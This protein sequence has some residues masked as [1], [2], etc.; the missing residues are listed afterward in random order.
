MEGDD[1]ALAR[2]DYPEFPNVSDAR[3][4]RPLVGL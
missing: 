2:L 1:G 3:K 4:V